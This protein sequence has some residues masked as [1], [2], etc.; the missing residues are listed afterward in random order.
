MVQ[1]NS[2]AEAVLATFHIEH[3]V[4]GLFLA[5]IT[6]LVIIGG[7]KSIGRVTSVLVPIMIVFYIIAAIAVIAINY[8]A[9]P[10]AIGLVFRH[11]FTPT[12][13]TG[14]FLGALVMQTIRLGVSRGVFSNESGLG[15]APIA[16]AAAQTKN[17][18]SQ[19][20]VSMTQT[21]IDTI[22]VCSLTGF[23]IISTGLWNS[24]STG[25]ELTARA[26]SHGLPGN[27]G[28]IIVAVCLIL[29]AY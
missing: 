29:F 1:S 3:W 9:L 20:L 10:E 15:S 2:V 19:A 25:S 17:P 16:A 6:G 7:I 18:V 22:I 21:F 12:A 5:V 28:G 23:A 27:S 4:T 11:A 24:G 13:A 8:R 14:G 26:F